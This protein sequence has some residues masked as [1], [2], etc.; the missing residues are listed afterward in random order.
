MFG[1]SAFLS[2]FRD[3]SAIKFII[4][5]H[6]ILEN[7]VMNIYDLFHSLI[8]THLNISIP[9]YNYFRKDRVKS[10]K[11][12]RASGGVVVFL[13]KIKSEYLDNIWLKLDKMFFKLKSDL[14]ICCAYLP[15][16]NSTYLHL[17]VPN[18]IMNWM[19]LKF[20][21]EILPITAHVEIYLLLGI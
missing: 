7:V 1:L 18:L 14:F 15:P 16:L 12:K 9:G 19:Y 21:K 5:I 8:T 20:L 3:K 6:S 10:K 2:V 4:F 17:V 13:I 11:A